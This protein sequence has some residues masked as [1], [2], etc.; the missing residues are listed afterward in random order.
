MSEADL[1]PI[2]FVARQLRVPLKWLR[3]E[4]LAGR[5]PAIDAGGRL[6]C[7]PAAVKAALLVRAGADSRKAVRHGR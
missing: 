7:D 6:L 2:R 4:A 3:A 5:V 1:L